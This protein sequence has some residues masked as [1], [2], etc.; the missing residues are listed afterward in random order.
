MPTGSDPYAGSSDP[1]AGGGTDPYA[2]VTDIPAVLIHLPAYNDPSMMDGSGMIRMPVVTGPVCH[3]GSDPSVVEVIRI[4]VV[5]VTSI[6]ERRI[7]IHDGRIL[8]PVAG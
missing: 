5:E 4:P 2:V 8:M 3:G 7:R 6:G 1:Y